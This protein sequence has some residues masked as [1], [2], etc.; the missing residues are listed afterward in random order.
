MYVYT[1]VSD[2]VFVYIFG[3]VSVYVYLYVFGQVYE[4]LYICTYCGCECVTFNKM[5]L[6]MLSKQIC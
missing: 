1:S 2:G 4:Y 6:T 3:R 5:K